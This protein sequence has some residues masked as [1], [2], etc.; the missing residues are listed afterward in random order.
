MGHTA[1]D[2][3]EWHMKQKKNRRNQPTFNRIIQLLKTYKGAPKEK[4]RL[5]Q[6]LFF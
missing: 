2:D 5:Q 4:V 1:A 6:N 3:A